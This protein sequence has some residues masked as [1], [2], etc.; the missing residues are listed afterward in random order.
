[1]SCAEDRLVTVD[2]FAH[3]SLIMPYL[4]LQPRNVLLDELG[5]VHPM[6]FDTGMP[7]SQPDETAAS[8]RPSLETARRSSQR[9]R[10]ARPRCLSA[11]IYRAPDVTSPSPCYWPVVQSAHQLTLSL[12]GLPHYNNPRSWLI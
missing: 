9:A 11:K 10:L 8:R 2:V 7:F 3:N 6:D 4:D 12:G 5:T 1:M